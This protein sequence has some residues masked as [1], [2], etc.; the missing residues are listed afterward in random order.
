VTHRRTVRLSSESVNRCQS[1]ATDGEDRVRRRVWDRTV[2]LTNGDLRPIA[3]ENKRSFSDCSRHVCRR[4]ARIHV[5]RGR[6]LDWTSSTCR[7]SIRRD[8]HL[9]GSG[10]AVKSFSGCSAP[11]S[12]EGGHVVARRWGPWAGEGLRLENRLD[13]AAP[14]P[15]AAGAASSP[16]LRSV[17]RVR[18]RRRGEEGFPLSARDGLRSWLRRV[19]DRGRGGAGQGLPASKASGEDGLHQLAGSC[20]EMGAARLWG[21]RGGE[22]RPR[23]PEDRDQWWGGKRVTGAVE[24]GAQPRP[25]L[26]GGARAGRRAVSTFSGPP[27]GTARGS[28]TDRVPLG[29]VST[30]PRG[31]TWHALDMDRSRRRFLGVRSTGPGAAEDRGVHAEAVTVKGHIALRAGP[32]SIPDRRG[33]ELTRDELT[34]V[35]QKGRREPRRP[36]RRG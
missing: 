32:L 12:G 8:G 26:T 33:P 17:E 28:S 36:R 21:G 27:G 10:E 24:Q 18:D 15:E 31:S 3:V 23:R 1:R 19:A 20:G 34:H 4:D 35:L 13:A 25:A 14:A 30:N 29:S 6:A 2:G 22:A 9:V 16:T 5:T 7:T 11:S